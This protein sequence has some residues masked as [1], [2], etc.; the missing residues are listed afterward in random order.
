MYLNLDIFIHCSSTFQL[1][2]LKQK[3]KA[4]RNRN[5][6]IQFSSDVLNSLAHIGIGLRQILL[7]KHRTDQL[8]HICIFLQQIQLL[9]TQNPR[10]L[11]ASIHFLSIINNLRMKSSINSLFLFSFFPFGN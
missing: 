7:H 4:P 3:C 9:Q 8:V 11:K 5:R 2:M 10:N 6:S 1:S